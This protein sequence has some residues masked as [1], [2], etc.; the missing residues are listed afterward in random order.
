[1]RKLIWL[2]VIAGLAYT[3]YWFIGAKSTEKAIAGWASARASEGWQ[4]EYSGIDTHGFPLR[5]D[6]T[7]TKP[8]FADPRTGVAF[9]T[10]Q[11]DILSQ[12]H[13]PT[14]IR[15]QVAPTATLAT[16]LQRMEIT[17]DR[18]EAEL[19]V[20][21]GP[22]LTLDHASAVLNGFSVTSNL[23]WGVTL[24]TGNFNTQR[25]ISDPFK[26]DIHLAVQGLTP[27]QGLMASLDPQGLLSHQFEQL[28]LRMTTTFNGPWDIHALEGP[29]PQPT[30]IDLTNLS[31]KWGKLDLRMTGAFDVDGRGYPMGTVAIKAVNWRE[32]IEIAISTGMIPQ[33][34]SNL[35]LRAGEMLA[36]MSGRKDTID[37]E[38]TLKDG[39][40]TLG[41][42]PLGPAPRV[43]IR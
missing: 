31:A 15:A 20:E 42:I 41:F 19:F 4:A 25:D 27:S 30:H 9:S 34:M 32:M 8:R 28:E 16:P 14:R 13:R 18:A 40:I 12:S 43:V 2:V 33:N 38:L 5:F 11:F 6:T 35:A 1:M 21:P 29:R 3:G 23:G 24:E 37:A 26:H 22:S 17:Q 10:P 7:I 39:M 36:G